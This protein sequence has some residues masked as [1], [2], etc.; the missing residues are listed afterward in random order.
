MLA[1]Q[2]ELESLVLLTRDPVFPAPGPGITLLW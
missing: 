2:A 1:A